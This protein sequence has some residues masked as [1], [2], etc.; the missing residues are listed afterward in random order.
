[1]GPAHQLIIAFA[2]LA[3]P[4]IL[5]VDEPEANAVRAVEKLGGKVA[6]GPDGKVRGVSFEGGKAADA[7]LQHLPHFPGLTYLNLT[8]SGVT[9]SGLKD[10]AALRRLSFLTL[11]GTIVTDAGLK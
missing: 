5:R 8:D 10:V 2:S 4:A 3:A 9:D 11:D 1:M 6:R 7:G